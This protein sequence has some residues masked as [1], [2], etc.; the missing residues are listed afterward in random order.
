MDKLTNTITSEVDYSP[1]EAEFFRA[2]ET[3]M[4][5]NRRRFPTFR[6]V[7][8]VARSLGYRKVAEPEELPRFLVGPSGCKGGG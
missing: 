3:Y 5:E 4:R 6:E 1:D 7:L 8:A 2:M